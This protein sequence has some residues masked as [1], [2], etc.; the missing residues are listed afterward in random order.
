MTHPGFDSLKFME[1]TPDVFQ[2][3]VTFIKIIS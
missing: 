3:L 2:M 1:D